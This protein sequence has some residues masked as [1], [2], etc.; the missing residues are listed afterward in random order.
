MEDSQLMPPRRPIVFI[1]FPL[2][3][4]YRKGREGRKE[5]RASHRMNTNF[6]ENRA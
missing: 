1:S 2:A 5:K 4:I 3:K 6:R